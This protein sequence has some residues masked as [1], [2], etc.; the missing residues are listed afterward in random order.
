MALHDLRIVVVDGGSASSGGGNKSG[1]KNKGGGKNKAD[2]TESKLYKTLNF[3][4]EVKGKIKKNT[5]PATFYALQAGASIATQTLK[6]VANFYLSDIGRRNGDSNYQ[7][8]VNRTLEVVGDVTS[9]LGGMHSGAAAGSALGPI[10]AAIGAL[11][12]GV[13]SGISL[14]FKYA[15]KERAYQHE[16]FKENMS[17]AYNLARANYSVGTGRLR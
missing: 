14:G 10:G 8:Q 11:A 13:S 3:S 17:Q 7:A 9:V 1:A 12:G 15:E 2:Y 5:N 6:Q 4:E 16:M